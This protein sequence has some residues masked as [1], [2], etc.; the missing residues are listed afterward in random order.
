MVLLPR[1]VHLNYNQIVLFIRDYVKDLQGRTLAEC[2]ESNRM[3]LKENIEEL[4]DTTMQT[5]RYIILMQRKQGTENQEA[6]TYEIEILNQDE[7][8]TIVDLT[9]TDA[10]FQF[11]AA[12]QALYNESLLELD[13]EGINSVKKNFYFVI[14][15][16]KTSLVTGGFERQQDFYEFY[17]DEIDSYKTQFIAMAIGAIVFQVVVMFVLLPLII[18]IQT[19]NKQIISLMA[20]I[21]NKDIDEE[22]MKIENYQESFLWETIQKRETPGL[23]HEFSQAGSQQDQNQSDNLK[24]EEKAAQNLEINNEENFCLLYTSDAADEEDSVDLGS[25]RRIKKKNK[26]KA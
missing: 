15:N 24:T 14:Q 9:Y 7:T 11:I 5:V 19:A 22:I 18:K 21:P 4:Q 6:K 12:A 20:M 16:G 13:E 23:H 26:K 25:R 10:N 1:K 17:L 2:V 8:E 3:I